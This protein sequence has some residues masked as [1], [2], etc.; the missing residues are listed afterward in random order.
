MANLFLTALPGAVCAETTAFLE[1][2]INICIYFPIILTGESGEREPKE[3]P[4]RENGLTNTLNT[5]HSEEYSMLFLLYC[6]IV[7]YGP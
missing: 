1:M 3:E 6:A 5:L 7:E 2:D 4:Y